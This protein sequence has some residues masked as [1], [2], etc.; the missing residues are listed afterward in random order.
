MINIE[1]LKTIVQQGV[2]VMHHSAVNHFKAQEWSRQ[3]RMS[4]FLLVLD[5][6]TLE[7][8]A[9]V[10]E[11]CGLRYGYHYIDD[12]LYAHLVGNGRKLIV[13]YGNCQMHDYYD[14]MNRIDSFCMQYDSVYFK[15]LE[16]PRWKE[17]R[18]ESFLQIA[19]VLIY[20][21]ESFDARF[22]D[23]SGFVDM[24]NRDCYKIFIPTYSFRGYF[25]Q[26]NPYIQQKAEFDIVSEVFNTYHRE[27]LVLNKMI[28]AG[29]TV[30]DM[31]CRVKSAECFDVFVIED[32]MNTSL[33]Q[34][35]IMDRVSAVKIGSFIRENYSR[36]RLFKDPVHMED[37]LIYFTTKE[38]MELLGIEVEI[39]QFGTQTVHYFSELPI[40]PEVRAYLGEE[41]S[42]E[43]EMT[44]LRLTEGMIIL[45]LEGYIRRYCAFCVNA[46]EIKDS[47][48]IDN[49]KDV[50]AEWFK[51]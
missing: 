35:E 9:P 30:E 10:L 19:D 33:L 1:S 27:D 32:L 31:I 49:K 43:N 29:Y 2:A 39:E 7:R 8:N 5:S 34:I 3:M 36:K 23:C 47:L 25:P 41:F 42:K 20:T 40:Y 46:H 16:Y 45:D 21:K 44:Q 28:K 48:H 22:R 15:Y 4:P 14:C 11:E 12:L 50:V 18:L 51:L 6:K 17:D 38:L 24:F 37:S 26:T 13:M